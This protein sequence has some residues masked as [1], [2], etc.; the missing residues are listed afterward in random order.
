MAKVRI[1]VRSNVRVRDRIRPRY[2]IL[3]LFP[4]LM[5]P[6]WSCTGISSW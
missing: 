1:R 5:S 2:L 6:L 3:L 4:R